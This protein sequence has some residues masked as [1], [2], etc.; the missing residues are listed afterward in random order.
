[1]IVLLTAAHCH[2]PGRFYLDTVWI[3]SI[4]PF[5]GT[6]RRVINRALHPD[7]SSFSGN[8]DFMVLKLNSP[9]TDVKPVPLASTP[10]DDPVSGDQITVIGFGA[11]F[12]GDSGVS[13]QLQEVRLDFIPDTT[14]ARQYRRAGL[15]IDAESEFCTGVLS[16]GGGKDSCQ[17][18]SGGPVFLDG[19]QVGVVSWGN[20]CARPGF[21]GVNARVSD[22]SAWIQQQ[23]CELSENPPVDCPE[24]TSP[25]PNQENSSNDFLS[26]LFGFFG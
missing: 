21:S 13:D 26:W 2:Q 7:Y 25:P 4:T 12:E 3:D 9:V 6:P 11:K 19:V 1:M 8:H 15:S 14:C 22:A 24:N 20:G 18:D 16:G 10:L 5:E 17:G 23:I